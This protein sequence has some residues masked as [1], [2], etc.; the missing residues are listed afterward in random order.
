MCPAEETALSISEN[1]F[2]CID[3]T[4]D[5]KDPD[6]ALVMTVE[7]VASIRN[8]QLQDQWSRELIECI[9]APRPSYRRNLVR[10]ARCYEVV[11]GLLHR[12]LWTDQEKILALCLPKSMRKDALENFH[13]S[14]SMGHLGIRKTY[15]KIRK[16][17][18]WP[19]IHANVIN[20][21]QSCHA[22][23][24]RKTDTQ[25]QVGKLQPLPPVS[26]PFKRIGMDKLG[27]LPQSLDGNKYIFV[28]TDYCTRTV[29]AKATPN[30]TASEA[31]KF[32]L[33][34]VI[35]RYNAPKEI[36]TDRGTEFC[37]ELFKSVTD[38]WS[39][40]HRRTTAYHPRTNG[41][42]ERFNKT[43]ADMMSH[44]VSEKHDDWDRYLPFLVHAYNTA[45]HDTLG[46]SP[47]E[48][49]LGFTPDEVPDVALDLPGLI[50]DA[51]KSPMMDIIIYRTKAR[52]IAAQRL[53]KSQESSAARFDKN[54]RSTEETYK[55][56]DL[57]W[58]KYPKRPS[59]GQAK[60]LKYQYTGPHRLR[61]QTAV[62]DFEIEDAT[63]KIEIVNADRF[64]RYYEREGEIDQVTPV[65]NSEVEESATITEP[66][67][68]FD[69]P[70]I[71]PENEQ[72]LQPIRKSNRLTRQP[73][74][75][76][77]PS[78]YKRIADCLVTNL[79]AW[80]RQ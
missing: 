63:G 33:H 7:E 57:V 4:Q 64:K 25:Q 60:K 30:G 50:P 73:E 27:P 1:I 40:I 35:L 8:L 14:P 45:S 21:V 10:A 11:N 19:K 59:D 51:N 46:Y 32:F 38:L 41:L 26:R 18:F 36:V 55:V 66:K 2:Q 70:E 28:V 16:R 75:Y 22:C 61:C 49:L 69:P 20:Y 62:N 23:N 47:A 34:D 71:E 5:N 48:L 79:S 56:G 13:D 65:K 3:D 76:S 42:T 43:I 53:E 39:A 77:D 24:A 9:E 67:S 74:R 17:Y 72:P 80:W 37:N 78:N 29:I 58:I 54:K 44:Y 31:A 68:L 15:H 12:R 52:E 6:L